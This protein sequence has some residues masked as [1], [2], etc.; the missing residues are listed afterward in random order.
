MQ[1]VD[2]GESAGRRLQAIKQHACLGRWRRRVVEAWERRRGGRSLARRLAPG[3]FPMPSPRAAV[4]FE[5]MFQCEQNPDQSTIEMLAASEKCT[6]FEVK[7]WFAQRR[8]NGTG[9]LSPLEQV[10]LAQQQRIARLGA[11]QKQELEPEPEAEPKAGLARLELSPDLEI[12]ALSPHSPHTPDTPMRRQ[13]RKLEERMKEA[14]QQSAAAGEAASLRVA[15]PPWSG[16][17]GDS[18]RSVHPTPRVRHTNSAPAALSGTASAQDKTSRELTTA[19]VSQMNSSALCSVQIFDTLARGDLVSTIRKS[20]PE[21]SRCGEAS[22]QLFGEAGYK[23]R[24]S[25]LVDVPRVE[26]VRSRLCGLVTLLDQSMF[27]LNQASFA[28]FDGDFGAKRRIVWGPR[29]PDQGLRTLSA[30]DANA[31]WESNATQAQAPK[32]VACAAPS[33]EP[34]G[35]M[36]ADDLLFRLQLQQL[37]TRGGLHGQP[38]PSSSREDQQPDLATGASNSDNDRLPPV[39]LLPDTPPLLLVRCM[40]ARGHPPPRLLTAVSATLRV[41][42]PKPETAQGGQ[43]AEV[44][45]GYKVGDLCEIFSHSGQVWCPG[46]V[47]ALRSANSTLHVEYLPPGAGAGGERSKMIKADSELLRPRADQGDCK[48]MATEPWIEWSPKS[49]Y[50]LGQ[51]GEVVVYDA[52][53]AGM[54]RQSSHVCSVKI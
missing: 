7:T 3:A 5:R 8:G 10:Q 22:R 19:V 42:E 31:Q 40:P 37:P 16:S 2:R 51:M 29:P 23:T 39:V 48:A 36:S 38:T 4:K 50:L 18:V 35:V 45:G 1:L 53:G 9:E 34:I 11:R 47:K 27:H 43:S 25:K 46:E 33:E 41:P 24:V 28:E 30:E 17:G 20:A 14:A 13:L 15:S 54:T 12:E 44:V 49:E 26:I 52:N 6:P 21:L 32:E